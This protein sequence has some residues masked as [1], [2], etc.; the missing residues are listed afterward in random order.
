[1]APTASN[2]AGE[3]HGPGQEWS[4]GTAERNPGLEGCL[5]FRQVGRN[6]EGVSDRK[7]WGLV[8]VWV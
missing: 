3:E 2:A 1:M 5:D 8:K 7:F 6:N 4:E